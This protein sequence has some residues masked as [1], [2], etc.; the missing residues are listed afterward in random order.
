MGLK[1]L[2]GS[3]EEF[4]TKMFYKYEKKK[5]VAFVVILDMKDANVNDALNPKGLE[6]FTTITKEIGTR[7]PRTW[8]A[9]IILNGK[10]CSL[11]LGPFH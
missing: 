4:V 5:C 1:F 9:F 2:W 10:K 6:F 3:F 7:F 11:I 8:H